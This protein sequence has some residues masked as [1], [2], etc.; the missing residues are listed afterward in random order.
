MRGFQ[1]YSLN[2]YVT[3]HIRKEKNCTKK[4][5]GN[6][7]ISLVVVNTF[8]SCPTVIVVLIVVISVWPHKCWA[9]KWTNSVWGSTWH[10]PFVLMFVGIGMT[11]FICTNFMGVN[12]TSF[13]WTDN[14]GDQHNQLDLYWIL[15][16]LTWPG[17][18]F[19]IFKGI[20][21][22]Y[23]ICTEVC[24]DCHDQLYLCWY[25]WNQHVK[26]HL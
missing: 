2:F 20:N 11:S 17:L 19:L 8:S 15:W 14:C 1:F 6:G 7:S 9:D 10:A 13:I 21:M 16:G 23:S 22:T 18:C 26:H 12:M 24:G 4:N 3:N 25:V 5:N